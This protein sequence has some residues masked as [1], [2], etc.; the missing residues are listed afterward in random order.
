MH[1]DVALAISVF[2]DHS[3]AHHL[4]VPGVT[5]MSGARSITRE[6]VLTFL[7]SLR[8]I[9][10][11]AVI[12]L[13]YSGVISAFW[14]VEKRADGSGWEL[15]SL[16]NSS[17]DNAYLPQHHPLLCMSRAVRYQLQSIT[18]CQQIL[19]VYFGAR[20]AFGLRGASPTGGMSALE[21]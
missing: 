21:V 13:Y 19:C 8:W 12:M 3:P 2:A 5:V 16:I 14:R 7:P 9:L 6:A 18:K 20:I 10:K 15:L 4:R 17:L 1:R 11:Y